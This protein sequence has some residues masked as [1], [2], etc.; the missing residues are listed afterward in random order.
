MLDLFCSQPQWNKF[1]EVLNKKNNPRIV[2]AISEDVW[3]FIIS[4]CHKHYGLPTLV[5]SSTS[6]RA[7]GL[8]G[9][10]SHLTG[11][12]IYNFPSLGS[13]I[14]AKGKASDVMDV[15]ERLR[16]I[17][18]INNYKSSPFLIFSSINALMNLLD[19][20]KVDGS[21]VFNLEKGSKISRERIIS[22]L[23]NR[24]YDR[25]NMVYDRGEFSV[26]GSLIDVYGL[27]TENPVRVD[28][29]GDEISAIYSFDPASHKKIEGKKG[30]SILP[31]SN[32]WEIGDS[33]NYISF[34]D[35]LK[36]RVGSF[37][38]V[39]CD[40]LEVQIKLKS[41][42]D[43][44]YKIL[45]SSRDKL[46]CNDL[47][48]VERFLISTNFMQSAGYNLNLSLLTRTNPESR[49]D[50]AFTINGQKK[51]YGNA[52]T[53][54]NNL[55]KDRNKKIYISIESK[56]R[57][58]KVKEILTGSGLSFKALKK[59]VRAENNVVN[60]CRHKLNKGFESESCSLYGEL[61]IY[62]Q[63]ERKIPDKKLA[64]LKEFEDFKSGE[65]IVHKTHGIGKYVDIISRKING[66]K[67]DYFLLEYANNDKLYVP[68]WQSD[69][70]NRYIGKENPT[71]TTLNSKQ[72]ENTKK[73]VRNSVKKL[74]VN[75][76]KL[77]AERQSR[78]G[79]AFPEDSPWQ[80]EIDSLFPFRETEDQLNAIK[81]VKQAMEKPKPMDMLI[82]GDVGFGKTEVAIRAAFKAIENGKQVMMLVPTT[83]LADQHYHT[84]KQR[85]DS[86]PVIL[87]VLSRFRKKSRQQ[88]II[89]AFNEG[90]IDM[91]IGTHRILQKDIKPK[92]L[93]LI[94]I[95]EEQRFG[96][97]SKEKIKLFK[98]NVDVL[99]LSAT[100]IPRTLYM[101]LT[102]IR[103]IA[104]IDT[105]PEG[106]NPIE[107]FVGEKDNY[108]VKQAIERE[109]GR[110]GQ[111]YYVYN[112]V[113][114]ID[115]KK[116]QLGKIVPGATIAV[117][118][119]QM[120][121][122][123]IEGIMEDFVEKKY[124]VLLTTTII[125]SGMDI[126]NV[127][128]LIVENADRF[129]L[130][131]LYQLRGRVGRTSTKAYAYFFYPSKRSLTLTALRR[132]KTLAEN[133]ELG[134]GYNIALRD[135]EIRGA[136]EILGPRQHGHMD[137]VGFEMYCQIIRE[138]I[139]KLEGKKVE[140][141]LNIQIEIPVS[142]YIPKTFIRK[143]SERINIYKGLGSAKS[144]KEI[145]KIKRQV[146]DRHGMIPLSFKNLIN[147]SKI[148]NLMK[149]A[150]IGSLT[151]SKSRSIVLKKVNLPIKDIKNISK[152]HSGI[153][154][155]IKGKEL[156]LQMED[157][158]FDLALVYNVLDDIISSINLKKERGIKIG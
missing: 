100:P 85:Y 76:S 3:P 115:S 114:H 79:Y 15:A 122:S 2:A 134:S 118:H 67:K 68:T 135:L 9:E 65:Y 59:R 93:G 86:F 70:I 90:K 153:K 157:K 136:G 107:T 63:E 139:G 52:S 141:D 13:S 129:G 42:K 151:F 105:H 101:S 40:P 55:K 61:D 39:I 25:V 6:D 82:C 133:T 77:Y 95:D 144:I 128:T 46:V 36:M 104:L 72:W 21:K 154:Y 84:F 120:A 28:L 97:N 27:T 121:G 127:N 4:A 49:V 140:E 137:S 147:I 24:G 7:T 102:G 111:V 87:E 158:N 5:V 11:D 119:G 62:E 45:N 16:V 56:K 123:K 89:R 53:F 130:S 150:K 31:M 91:V 131:Q 75:L 142:A 54:I 1:L 148:K 38:L 152:L 17:K 66:H 22:A 92:D 143:E 124:D 109:I 60:L 78:E 29:F 117:T 57:M 96:V 146:E 33:R 71:I 126:G 81:E 23:A 103:D 34:I 30:I 88:K 10:T 74:A 18:K 145:E 37:N 83:I 132:L 48:D 113:E 12:S 14:F 106:R 108:I 64:S 155:D 98:K 43:I 73:K 116:E 156:L 99:T 32:P 41:D 94:I 26:R 149:K 35:F 69:R 110:G 44:L 80:K 112:R 19:T 8:A 20:D 58:S 51:S 47:E 138:E 50:F 125:E